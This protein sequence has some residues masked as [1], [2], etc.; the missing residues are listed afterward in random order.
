[1][2]KCRY[3]KLG[4]NTLKKLLFIGVLSALL[5]AA[6]ND[7]TDKEP[8][9]ANEVTVEEETKVE[10]NENVKVE[11]VEEEANENVEAAE[12]P[13]IDTS[14]F[15]YAKSVEVTDARD[16]NKHITLQ[17]DLNDDAK[18]GMGTQHVLNQMYD[19]LQQEDING[20]ETVTFY[21]R[22]Q[23]QKVAQFTTTIAN[24]KADPETPMAKV[25]LNASEIEKLNPEVDAYGKTMGLW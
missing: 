14:I 4:G 3:L 9:E 12:E 5:L 6:C 18:A 7:E 8:V 19:F 23:E 1:M 2:V 11:A 17:I 10:T 15:E 13:G 22:L 20:A 25:V 21:V 16:V 24:F